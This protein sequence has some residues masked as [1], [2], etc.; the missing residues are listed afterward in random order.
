[1]SAPLLPPPRLAAVSAKPKA[2]VL[3]AVVGDELAQPLRVRDDLQREAQ[4]ALDDLMAHRPGGRVWE[5][6]LAE[7]KAAAME[8]RSPKVYACEKWLRQDGHRWA[9]ASSLC[10]SLAGRQRAVVAEL[11]HDEIASAA[12]SEME[13]AE[14][15][16]TER[17][18]AAWGL[19]EQR[20]SAG[21]RAVAYEA[22]LEPLT[23]WSRAGQV[24]RWARGDARPRN[25]AERDAL[26]ALK[27]GF[28]GGPTGRRYWLLK[29]EQAGAQPLVVPEHVVEAEAELRLT[30]AGRAQH[31]A[32][33]A[34]GVA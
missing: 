31:A 29:N 20:A 4:Q 13:Q 5:A 23:T 24:W 6:A 7:D 32:R 15:T 8:G 11:G 27:Y 34:S 12:W 22:A 16:W 17:V 26:V 30:D 18:V 10:R 19:R 1:M 2:D 25:Q 21:R 3:A 9:R 14:M 33:A 28:P